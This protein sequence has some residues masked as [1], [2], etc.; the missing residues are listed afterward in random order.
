MATA[1]PTPSEMFSDTTDPVQIASRFEDYKATLAKSHAGAKNDVFDPT[2]KCIVK[3]ANAGPVNAEHRRGRRQQGLV[4]DLPQQHRP[5]P[6]RP[7]GAGEAAGAAPH[8]A[9]QRDPAG[10]G[11]GTA[12]QF[13]RILG[14]SNSGVGGVADMSPFMNS[15]TVQTSFGSLALRRGSK[16]TYASDSKSVAYVEMSLS[17]QVNWV[18]QFAGQGFQDIRPVPDRAA[19][20]AHG[21]RRAR[22][23]L[24]PRLPA[25]ATRATSPHR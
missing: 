12:R 18:S 15:Q 16:I 14:W 4:A 3:G 5:G 19:V 11:Q 21:R 22:H 6:L 2:A 7:G 17:D 1:P 24:R 20:G 8:P 25:T 23:A 13:K 9:A 10:K